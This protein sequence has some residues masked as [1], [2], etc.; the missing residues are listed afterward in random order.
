MVEPHKITLKWV[1]ATLQNQKMISTKNVFCKDFRSMWKN[2]LEIFHI[3]NF[4]QSPPKACASSLFK[5]K[6][7]QAPKIPKASSSQVTTSQLRLLCTE[8]E[9]EEDGV[10]A[11]VWEIGLGP[12][13][14]S[15]NE[16]T[17]NNNEADNGGWEGKGEGEE[18]PWWLGTRP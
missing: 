5:Q 14:T 4:Q 8:K 9:R 11:V 17:T 6:L 10:A 15:A 3:Q 2:G 16:L 13:A 12:A 7:G 1:G 18:V